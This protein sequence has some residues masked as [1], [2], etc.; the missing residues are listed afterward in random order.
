MSRR[1]NIMIDEDT[2]LYE[3]GNTI[4]R[5]LPT[6]ASAWLSAFIKFGIEEAPSSNPWLV[7]TLVGGVCSGITI[8]RQKSQAQKGK[9]SGAC[10]RGNEIRCS[11]SAF[12]VESAHTIVKTLSAER[13]RRSCIR[14]CASRSHG[15][16]GRRRV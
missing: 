2:W 16:H 9:Y 14:P 11:E 1:I 13:L 12:E 10:E 6:Q 5:R 3:V 4:A 8:S 7:R 15:A